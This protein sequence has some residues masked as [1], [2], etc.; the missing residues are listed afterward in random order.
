MKYHI[1]VGTVGFNPKHSAYKGI[2][3]LVNTIVH[4]AQQTESTVVLDLSKA[5]GAI[6]GS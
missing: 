1:E 2:V 6:N 3:E 4:A 5:F